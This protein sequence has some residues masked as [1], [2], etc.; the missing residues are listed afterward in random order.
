MKKMYDETTPEGRANR[1]RATWTARKGRLKDD[2]S[3]SDRDYWLSRT[4]VER[5]QAVWDLTVLAWEM[6]G[7]DIAQLRLDRTAPWTKRRLR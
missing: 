4:P 5:G 1:R 7:I 6:K 2:T 3:K